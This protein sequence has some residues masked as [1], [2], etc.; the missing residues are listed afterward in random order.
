M[1]NKVKISGILFLMA[2]F[3]LPNLAWAQISCESDEHILV[4]VVR[5]PDG[6]FIPGANIKLYKQIYDADGL[7]KPG[8]E[9]AS[10]KTGNLT[11][12]YQKKFG[13]NLADNYVLKVWIDNSKE[14]AFWFYDIYVG[15]NALTNYTANLSAIHVVIRDSQDELIK[16]KSFK[17]F[18]QKQDADGEPIKETQDLVGEYNTSNEGEIFVYI[19]D[20]NRSLPLT[21]PK[22]M[23]FK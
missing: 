7:H 16:N 14:G 11:G 23:F 2:A 5:D 8:D 20:S 15:C 19:P 9:V 17:I 12:I 1:Q 18:T 21:V 22:H 10:G 13:S 4:I 6:E 3:L